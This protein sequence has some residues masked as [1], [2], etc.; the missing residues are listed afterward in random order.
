MNETNLNEDSQIIKKYLIKDYFEFYG[1]INCS[2]EMKYQIIYNYIKE[3]SLDFKK[4]CLEIGFP[5]NKNL[6]KIESLSFIQQLKSNNLIDHYQ[7]SLLFNSAN[8]GFY[9]IGNLPHIFKYNNFE[10]FQL[11]STYSIPNKPLFQ[12][13]ILFD[14]VFI[15]SK[16]RNKKESE[17]I[18]LKSNKMYFNLDLGL[19]IGTKEYFEEI[20]KIF[21]DEYYKNKICK[22]ETIRKNIYDSQYSLFRLKNYDIISCLKGKEND[23]LY[24]NIKLF[25]SLCFYHHEMN[26]TF[27]F[28]YDNLF[29]ENNGIY[30]F[31]IIY[32][33]NE[34]RE[35]QFGKPFLEKY[36]TTFDIESRKIY[37]YNKNIVFKNI[38]KTKGDETSFLLLIICFILSII[39]LGISYLLGKKIY[40]QRK[41]RKNELN[42]N[43]YDYK[44]FLF[45]ENNTKNNAIEMYIKA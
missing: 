26:F 18:N 16:T 44:S 31:K 13:Q 43:N 17:K 6:N 4:Y 1:N 5:I 14:E 3:N 25:P 38:R 23:R 42:D 29:E 30:Y 36:S 2:K 15:S 11:I 19:I 34:D 33:L 24:F 39:L 21:F 12:F 20:N 37:F 22:L 45:E 32:V 10:D 8:E 9:I 28:D 7:I 41:L 35:W 40:K 27:E